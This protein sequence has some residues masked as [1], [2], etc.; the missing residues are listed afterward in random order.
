MLNTFI[1]PDY[2]P[3]LYTA[4]GY[5]RFARSDEE[6]QQR[7]SHE[8]T[9]TS[10]RAAA[11]LKFRWGAYKEAWAAVEP[12]APGADKVSTPSQ[13]RKRFGS[14]EWESESF[15]R[16]EA[17]AVIRCEGYEAPYGISQEA[18]EIPDDHRVFFMAMGS[19]VFRSGVEFLLRPQGY[20]ALRQDQQ[21]YAAN[22]NVPYEILKPVILPEVPEA[23]S[24]PHDSFRNL[25]RAFVHDPSGLHL[26]RQR[27]QLPGDR[28][29]WDENA[30]WFGITLDRPDDEGA[31]WQATH[32]ELTV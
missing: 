30:Q 27:K 28:W 25:M 17:G 18:G 13:V 10:T 31:A 7:L 4:A 21:V 20:R 19:V 5:E 26:L 8:L 1:S 9:E 3:R 6:F 2:L 11:M 16:Y 24:S 23:G 15:L 22:S 32:H 14:N 29:A 12:Y